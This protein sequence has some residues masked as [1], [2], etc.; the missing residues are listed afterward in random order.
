MLLIIN[1]KSLTRQ[2]N[3]KSKPTNFPTQTFQYIFSK[4]SLNSP[5][6]LFKKECSRL[7]AAIKNE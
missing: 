5:L 7:V 6:T 1:N 4:A 3:S 2:E